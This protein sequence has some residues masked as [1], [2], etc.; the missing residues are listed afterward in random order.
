MTPET[1]TS[2]PA[3]ASRNRSWGLKDRLSG[4]ATAGVGFGILGT[5]AW[6]RPD[7]NGH[8]THEQLML[9]RCGWVNLFDK[10]CPT[11][12]MTTSFSHAAQGDLA[13]AAITQ[14]L[15]A[16]LSVLTA[17]LVWGGLHATLTGARIGGFATRLVNRWTLTCALVLML[18]AWVYKL[19]TWSG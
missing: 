6:L 10:P 18:A 4:L 9:P 3:A 15:G 1:H 16:V 8:G 11:C 13:Q 17:M 12:G 7:E 2:T 14:P 5:A 19:L